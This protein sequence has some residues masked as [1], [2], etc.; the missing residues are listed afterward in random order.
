SALGPAAN[1]PGSAF[2]ASQQFL[3]E[4]A[5]LAAQRHAQPIIVAP[6]RRWQPPAGLAARALSES[7]LAPWLKPASLVTLATAKSLP[8]V[9]IPH[10]AA[11]ASYSR[12]E[13]RSIAALVSKIKQLQTIRLRPDNN[14]YLAVATIESSA[15]QGK[16]P[17]AA[18]DMLKQVTARIANQRLA[19]HLIAEKRV[20]LGGLKG[21]V[22]V[23]IDNPLGYAIQV[24]VQ[25]VYNNA[26]GM[27]VLVDPPGLI[28]V[29]AGMEKTVHL[30]VQAAQVGST[31]ITVRLLNRKWQPLPSGARGMTIQATQVGVLGMIIF[32]AALGVFLI[33]SAFRAVRRGRP[34][35]PDDQERDVAGP[36]DDADQ[37]GETA[38]G[39]DTVM[40]ERSDTAGTPG[41]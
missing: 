32:A 2:A 35:T 25:P 17:D 18:M 10:V 34:S 30:R 4:T 36:A 26:S 22:P 9:R 6:P 37:G 28:T 8:T 7:A 38:A 3:A 29:Y 23:S 31:Q 16:S 24:R 20:T 19:V 21:R 13:L 15:W 5:V 1:V 40:A 14:L 12:S 39:A 33:A 27:K 41:P 11:Q